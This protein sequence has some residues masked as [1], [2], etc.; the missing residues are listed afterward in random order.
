ML[1]VFRVER[2]WC[3]V[4]LAKRDLPEACAML[5]CMC[6]RKCQSTVTVEEKAT[7]AHRAFDDGSA[8]Q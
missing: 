3:T 2:I 4:E 5:A 7:L 6:Q 1:D 8:M